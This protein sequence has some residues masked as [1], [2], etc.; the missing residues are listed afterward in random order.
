MQK[1][2]KPIVF[3]GSGPVAAKSLEML[4]RHCA[5]EAVVTKPRPVH[6]KGDVPVLRVAKEHN[7][8]VHTVTDKRSLDTLIDTSPFSSQLGILIDFGIIV[9]QKVIDYFSKGIINSHFS[10]LP[11]WRGAD[12][13]TFSILSGQKQTGVSLMLLTAGMDE[14]PLLAQAPYDISPNTTTPALTDA[15]IELSD[16][17]LQTVL[18][19]WAN[20]KAQALP[21]D[22]VTMAASKTPTYSRKLEKQDSIL[23]WNKPAEVLE[24]EIRAFTDW[25]KS[26]ATF[27]DLEVIITKAHVAQNAGTAGKVAI[28]GKKPAVYC[29][30]G[31]L[32]FDL[33]K[34]ASKKE[35]TGEAFLAGYKRLFL[36]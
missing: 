30:T 9:S 21:Q 14:G 26:R 13:I 6:H 27:G 19:L 16:N 36:S 29:S 31:A 4:M 20:G 32:V 12:P 35:M 8:T 25:P 11:E 3:F 7:L 10:L 17:A 33:I 23:D 22:L 34:P 18:P 2:S 28:I 24:R 15:L 1:I 5:I